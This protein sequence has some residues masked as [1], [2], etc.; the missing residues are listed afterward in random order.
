MQFLGFTV[1][2]T[3]RL[4]PALQPLSSNGGGWRTIVSEPYTGAWQR[5][6]E[7]T[8]DTVLSNPTVY[9]CVCRIASD[10]A[11]LGFRLVEKDQNGIWNETDSPSFSPVI[12]EPNR[13]QDIVSFTEQW[14]M[15]KLTWGNTYL[16][17]Q[18]DNRNVVTALYVLDPSRVTP[19]VAQDG[20]IYYELL[21]DDLSGLPSEKVTVPADWIIHDRMPA[22][23]HPLI[24]VSPIYA[25]GSAAV[26][27]LNIQESS[28]KFFGNGSQPGG[29]LTAPGAISDATAA[30][31]KAYWD[32][33]YTGDN[34]GKVA[35]LGDGLKY[36]KMRENAV[37]SQLI[38]QLG[39]SD[40]RICSCYG[41][42]PYMV[43]VGPAP[44]YANS[45]PVIQKYYSQCIQIHT[46]KMEKAWEKGLG[47]NKRID[48]R[49]LGVE[50]DISDL[51]WMDAMTRA[52]VSAKAIGSGAVSPNES[53][54]LHFGLGPVTGGDSPM[55]QQQNY[56]LAALSRRDASEDPFGTARPAA[57]AP[58]PD[59]N[60]DEDDLMDEAAAFAGLLHQKSREVGLY[61]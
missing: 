61:A 32:A 34:V 8:A 23:Y 45:D 50:Y 55:I 14:V 59:G 39:W 57:P 56:S 36:E 30:R 9:A 4:L 10:I 11:K 31:L 22:L 25:C 49:T 44:P 6:A 26:Q 58:A 1:A 52:E 46:V 38:L 33:N 20:S 47:L 13:Y 21:R 53:R 60:D 16:L 28:T 3:K 17:K 15:S 12:R 48:G 35:V 37:D 18:F 7:V 24:G 5:N 43:D 54:R 19:L 51:I 2:R 42:P 40:E 29:V 41:V 27:G